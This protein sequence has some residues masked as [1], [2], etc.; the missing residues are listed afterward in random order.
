VENLIDKKTVTAI[1]L[2]AGNSTRFGKDRNKNFEI[3]N[4]KS[5]LAYSLDAFDKNAYIDHIIVAIKECEKSKI[6]SIINKESLTK[7]VDIIIGGNTR[8]QSVYNCIKTINSD[9]VIIHDG[10]RPLIKQEYI[11]NCIENMKEFK[12]ASIGVKSKDTIKIT[13]E[14]NIVINTTNRNSTWLIQTPQCFDRLTLLKMHDKYKNED[15][16]DDCS[17]LE[18]DKYKVKIIQG[19]YSNIKIT[20]SEDLDIIKKLLMKI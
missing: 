6:N 10:A 8:K 9:I 14:N 5:V 11:I 17:L 4:G 16:T 2:V 3:L 15:V 13:D 1:I 7:N 12:G 20:T 19:D 18:K